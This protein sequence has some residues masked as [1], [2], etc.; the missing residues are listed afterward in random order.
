VNA[1]TSPSSPQSRR[2]P[3]KGEKVPCTVAGRDIETALYKEWTLI[4]SQ[5]KLPKWGIL[6]LSWA[7]LQTSQAW[8]IGPGV[9]MPN[10][11]PSLKADDGQAPLPKA[12][13][14][15]DSSL[16][17]FAQNTL[18]ANTLQR[19]LHFYLSRFPSYSKTWTA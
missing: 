4:A 13:Q 16:Y 7:H 19:Y 17:F 8:Q 9:Q 1:I 2:H 14:E 6:L 18:K 12:V 11:C 10:H 15:G 5:S 3:R